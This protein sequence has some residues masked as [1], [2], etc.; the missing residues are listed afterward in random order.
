MHLFPSF[1]LNE[2][3]S[4]LRY[5]CVGGRGFCLGAG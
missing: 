2:R 1:D 5:L 3:V 4:G